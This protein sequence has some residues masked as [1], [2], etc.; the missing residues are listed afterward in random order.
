LSPEAVQEWKG[1]K[2]R[3]RMKVLKKYCI[4]QEMEVWLY[5]GGKKAKKCICFLFLAH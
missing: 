4:F 5:G 2:E 3:R 1:I